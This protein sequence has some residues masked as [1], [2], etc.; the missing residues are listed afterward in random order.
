MLLLSENHQE[1]WREDEHIAWYLKAAAFFATLLVVVAGG[2]AANT[3][4]NGAVI[5]NGVIKVQSFS[6]SIQHLEGGLIN[7]ILVRDGDHVEAGEVLIKLDESD[8]DNQIRGEESQARSKEN[9][10]SLLMRELADL[11]KLEKKGLVQKPRLT[12]LER[13]IAGLLGEKSRHQSQAERLKDRLSRLEI[14]APIDVIIHDLE[15][16]TLN[17]VVAAGQEVLKIIPQTDELLVEARV[18]PA[19]IDQVQPLQGAVIRLSSFNR[20]ITPEM[21]A[22]I[23]HVSADLTEDEARGTSYYIVQ[24]K[25]MDLNTPTMKGVSLLP[26][27]PA[28]VFISTE[29]RT[30]MSYLVKP[31]TDQFQKAFRE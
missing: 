1:Y 12:A 15:F 14:R 16:H 26:G 6:K 18:S 9:Q 3:Q 10:I 11:E 25:L 7:E 5:A 23:T 24:L 27:M 19:D 20:S 4:I 29:A 17:G 28:D 13:Q 8:I 2:W 30:V 22:Q 21:E 31:F